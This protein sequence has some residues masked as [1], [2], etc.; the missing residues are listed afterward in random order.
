MKKASP[1]AWR[2]KRQVELTQRE[3]SFGYSPRRSGQTAIGLIQ[4]RQFCTPKGGN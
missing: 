1:Q 4:A 3:G 2:G